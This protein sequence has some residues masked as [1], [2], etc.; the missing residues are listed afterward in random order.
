[1]EAS[2]GTTQSFRTGAPHPQ[3]GW[4]HD[5]RTAADGEG[6]QLVWRDSDG[7][8]SLALRKGWTRVGRSLSAHLRFDDATVSR[9]HALIH[10]DD[11][12]VRLLEDHS[13]GGTLVNGEQVD[14]CELHDGDEITVGRF[15]IRFLHG[16]CAT[17]PAD[18]RRRDRA[19]A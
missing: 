1:M 19:I 2:P 5:A 16:G 8:H 7:P 14:W 9:R 10:R 11:D 15:R 13:T 17:E 3:P 6:D 18:A 4:S 12:G